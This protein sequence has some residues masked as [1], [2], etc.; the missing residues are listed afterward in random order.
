M[1]MEKE[2]YSGV[3]E[4]ERSADAPH[5]AALRLC[6]YGGYMPEATPRAAIGGSSVAGAPE[7]GLNLAACVIGGF[8]LAATLHPG[9]QGLGG[10]EN[11]RGLFRNSWEWV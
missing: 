11:F 4:L 5:E 10:V 8:G 3:D 7:K 2:G 6:R 9:D 1:G